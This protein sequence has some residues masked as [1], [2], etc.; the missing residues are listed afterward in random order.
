MQALHQDSFQHILIPTSNPHQIIA[1]GSLGEIDRI[2][3]VVE[4]RLAP[5]EESVWWSEGED[6]VTVDLTNFGIGNYDTTTVVLL[7][8][9]SYFFHIFYCC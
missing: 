4:Y 2:L 1:K 6:H 8:M 3:K 9:F 5:N 7:Q